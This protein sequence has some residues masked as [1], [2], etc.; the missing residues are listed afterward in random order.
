L[1]YRVEIKQP[2]GWRLVWTCFTEKSANDFRDEVAR[3]TKKEVRVE[4]RNR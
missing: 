1:V 2:I 4:P 3:N